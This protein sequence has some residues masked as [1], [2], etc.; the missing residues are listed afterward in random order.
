[1]PSDE[2]DDEVPIECIYVVWMDKNGNSCYFPLHHKGVSF[3]NRNGM[4][5]LRY[6][7]DLTM[8]CMLLWVLKRSIDKPDMSLKNS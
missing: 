5:T 3:Y 6:E 4:F 2:H 7:L 8:Q 1:M